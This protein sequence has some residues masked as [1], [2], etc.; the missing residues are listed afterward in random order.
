MSVRH[1]FDDD[2]HFCSYASQ[3]PVTKHILKAYDESYSKIIRRHKYKDKDNDKEND[4]DKDRDIVVVVIAEG[5]PRNCKGRDGP[6]KEAP[7]KLQS[8]WRPSL[9]CA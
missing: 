2:H 3:T 6:R 5:D 7:I 4:K 8:S 9:S 1:H